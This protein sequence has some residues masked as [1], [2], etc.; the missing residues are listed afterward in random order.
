[1]KCRLESEPKKKVRILRI[2]ARMNLGG[3]AIQI[4]GLFR[5]MN[6]NFFET[7]I[8][9][10][11]CESN[12]IDFLDTQA[13]DVQVTRLIGLGRSISVFS[14]LKSLIKLIRIINEFEPDIIHTHTAKAGVLGRIASLLSGKEAFRVHT[15]HGHLL[16]GY[17]S[18][19]RL[20]AV[21]LLERI[22]AR[23]THHFVAVGSNVR[24]D[25]LKVGIG[26]TKNF[27]VIYPGI[28]PI[29]SSDKS[30]ARDKLKIDIDTFVLTFI[31]RLE[32]IKRV[33]RLI[34]ALALLD[35]E[36]ENYLL[37]VAGDGSERQE[38]EK[39]CGDLG[40]KVRFLGWQTDLKDLIYSADVSIHTS[41]NEGIP[42]S[43]I[44]SSF[45]GIP[46]ISTRVGSVSD[47]VIN[48][49]TGLLCEKSPE[50]VAKAILRMNS[51]EIK[52]KEMGLRAKE[53]AEE[54]FTLKNLV[55]KHESLYLDLFN[56][57]LS[58]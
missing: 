45:C 43:L 14:D 17:F 8:V 44:Q 52:R 26:S 1:M 39:K 33:D 27:S 55:G 24:E 29:G 53:Y 13:Q 49:V 47:I 5:Q 46:S 16:Y 32:R 6:A 36:I 41:D 58:N 54:Q 25:L 21:I 18:G 40:I 7:Q 11:Y 30:V 15:F 51:D 10:G 37:I 35:N 12:E 23:F 4:T 42:V 9:T 2:I 22:L 38:L 34:D 28:V 57:N 50:S 56:K 31:G 48:E 19:W 20:R 3:P